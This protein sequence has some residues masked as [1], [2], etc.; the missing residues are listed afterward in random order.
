MRG[1]GRGGYDGCDACGGLVTEPLGPL[2]ETCCL[3]LLSCDLFEGGG[4][5]RGEMEQEIRE[6]LARKVDCTMLQIHA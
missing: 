2:A 1:L 4:I 5:K 6:L 3:G